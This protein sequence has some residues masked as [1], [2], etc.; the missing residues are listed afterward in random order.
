MDAVSAKE[1]PDSI[2]LGSRSSFSDRTSASMPLAWVAF[3]ISS[4]S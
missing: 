2:K 3:S 1:L 4:L